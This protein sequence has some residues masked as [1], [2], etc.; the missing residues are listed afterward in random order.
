MCERLR[1]NESLGCESCVSAYGGDNDLQQIA[2]DRLG[3]QSDILI[4][5]TRNQKEWFYSPLS[6]YRDIKTTGLT[7]SRL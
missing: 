3:V 4:V 1:R 5:R 7:P 6:L 2:S